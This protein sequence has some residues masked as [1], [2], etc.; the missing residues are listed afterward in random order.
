MLKDVEKY[1]GNVVGF[2]VENVLYLY[3]YIKPR[4]IEKHWKDTLG[5]GTLERPPKFYF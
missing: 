3:T 2:K 4:I 1:I 5:W